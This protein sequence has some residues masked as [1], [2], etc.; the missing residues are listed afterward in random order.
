MATTP[1]PVVI[2]PGSVLPVQYAHTIDYFEKGIDDRGPYYR[3]QYQISNWSD[4]DLF[5][6]ALLG[7]VT[8]TGTGSSQ[9]VVKRQ[10]HAHPLSPNLLCQRARCTGLGYPVLNSQGLPNYSGGALIEAEYRAPQWQTFQDPNQQVSDAGNFIYCTQ[11]I[12]LSVETKTIPTNMMVY[13]SGSAPSNGKSANVPFNILIPIAHLNLTF[14]KLPYIPMAAMRTYRGR[15]NSAQFLGANA[16][17][18]L[19]KGGRISRDYD[20]SGSIVQTVQMSFAERD[21]TQP[22]NSLPDLDLIWYPVVSSSGAN[23]PY[24]T[25]DLNNLLIF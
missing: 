11:E 19:F 13:N 24:P 2:P 20:T 22:W 16:G 4:S 18:V 21:T 6:N 23:S 9:G 17:C 12:E 25:A 14:F 10:P 8:I 7:Y 3:V 1:P 15:V 5:V